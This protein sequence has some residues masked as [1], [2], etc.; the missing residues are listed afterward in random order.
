MISRTALEI[1]AGVPAVAIA[2]YLVAHH[3][4]S[5]KE[6]LWGLILFAYFLLYYWLFLK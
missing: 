6:W 2:V 1:A 3:P 4:K 5:I